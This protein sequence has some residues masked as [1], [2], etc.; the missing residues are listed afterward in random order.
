[1]RVASV[2]VYASVLILIYLLYTGSVGFV[3]VLISVVSGLVVAYVFAG[4]LIK[5][6]SKLSLLRF[7]R[8]VC[9]LIYYFTVAEVKAHWDVV[10]LILSPGASYK[11]AI[12]RAPYDLNSEYSVFTVANSITNTPGTVV[13][14]IDEMRKHYYVHWINALSLDDN[15]VRKNVSLDFESR[16]R[17]VFE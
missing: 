13:V 14:D 9:F 17:G 3:E 2:I 4:D 10:K 7:L 8:L 5:D 15:E 16:V 1:M 6:L 11:P 12:V